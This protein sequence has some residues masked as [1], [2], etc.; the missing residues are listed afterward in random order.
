MAA[1]LF[2]SA[3]IFLLFMQTGLF[4]LWKNPSSRP[5]QWFFAVSAYLAV[6]TI[7][8]VSNWASGFG[9]TGFAVLLPVSWAVLPLMLFRFHALI[10]NVPAG[11]QK[12]NAIAAGFLLAGLLL[13]SVLLFMRVS[14]AGETVSNANT[15]AVLHPLF[16]TLV[17][18]SIFAAIL[19]FRQWCR[20]IPGQKEK[21]RFSVILFLLAAFYLLTSLLYILLP[22]SPSLNFI[23]MPPV[24][25]LPWYLAITFGFTRKI[26]SSPGDLT[27]TEKNLFKDLQQIVFICNMESVVLQ[28]NQFSIGLLGKEMHE[29]VGSKVVELFSGRDQIG[30]LIDIAHKNGHSEAKEMHLLTT[31][32]Q[33]IPVSVSCILLVDRFNDL[34]GFAVYGQDY[35]DVISLRNEINQRKQAEAS[36]HKMSKNLELEAEKRTAEMRS[37][38]EQLNLIVADRQRDEETL[39]MEVAEMEVMLNEIYTR[40]T[41]NIGIILTILDSA[42]ELKFGVIDQSEKKRL[43]RL[44]QRI[45]AI[46][47]VNKQL[48][49][50]QHYGMV[51][52]KQFLEMLLQRNSATT[53]DGFEPEMVLKAGDGLLW[54]D[55]AVPLALVAS[56]LITNAVTYAFEQGTIP[57][58]TVW[59]EY[60]HVDDTWCHFLVKDN[61]SGV[62]PD[63][64]G[65]HHELSGFSLAKMLVKDQLNGSFQ[66]TSEQG[67]SVFIRIPLNE[68]RQGHIGVHR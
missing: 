53:G 19:Q 56:E 38:V 14:W 29:V 32:N 24:Y 3:V 48:M 45:D 67:L 13:L 65:M 49:T 27:N 47:L 52:F 44:F 28:S 2:I 64:H 18:V 30:K 20:K 22:E 39:R 58:P 10:A 59:I 12:Q 15:S 6:L 16:V 63:A 41:K 50:E 37:F 25:L 55:Q 9:G 54:I 40:V 26:S 34:F 43:N 57:N 33:K 61:G 4:M 66:I 42:R 11:K 60:T 1:L 36:L 7:L 5:H 35:R 23:L 51:D 46:L 68:L 31:D 62:V 8:F 17:V 21:K